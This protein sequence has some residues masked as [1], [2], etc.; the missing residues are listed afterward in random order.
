ME[1]V[2]HVF[3]IFMPEVHEVDFRGRAGISTA[4]V[5]TVDDMQEWARVIYKKWE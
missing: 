2:A 4:Y 1:P 5:R 3:A